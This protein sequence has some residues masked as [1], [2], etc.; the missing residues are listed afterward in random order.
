M[1]YLDH[2][3]CN[4]PRCFRH[5][6]HLFKCMTT[7]MGLGVNA[8]LINSGRQSPG[9]AYCFLGV[10]GV[11]I[12]SQEWNFRYNPTEGPWWQNSLKAK[13]IAVTNI[14]EHVSSIYLEEA[15]EELFCKLTFHIHAKKWLEHGPVCFV[16]I[17]WK[18]FQNIPHW[19]ISSYWANT[20]QKEL[21]A[22]RLFLA[23]A[24]IWMN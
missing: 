15:E 24:S 9:S 16:S 21:S 6:E 12:N 7:G 18:L 1:K 14:A 13:I 22:S 10:S 11:C 8:E 23:N 2:L 20:L 17:L 4:V 5:F 3:L 19:W